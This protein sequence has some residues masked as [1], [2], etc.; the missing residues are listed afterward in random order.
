MK[1][2]KLTAVVTV[3]LL[4]FVG[5]M[6]WAQLGPDEPEDEFQED[7]E[8]PAPEEPPAE[9]PMMPEQPDVDVDLDDDEMYNFAEALLEVQLVQQDVQMEAQEMIQGSDI[10]LERFQ[11]I[12]LGFSDPSVPEPED[13][14]DEEQAEYEDV[15]DDVEEVEVAAQDEMEEIVE[16]HGMSVDRFNEVAM[17]ATQDPELSNELNQIMAELMQE[18]D[19]FQQQPMQPEQPEQPPEDEF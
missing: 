10:G 11:E 1:Q 8:E 3:V 5:T 4:T 7:L 18:H 17:V 13:V 16:D 2:V 9:D 12:H 14:T 15:I 6:A 19:E